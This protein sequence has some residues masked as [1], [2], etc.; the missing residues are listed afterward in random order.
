M[1]L[2]IILF[3]LLIASIV[4]CQLPVMQLLFRLDLS[5]PNHPSIY[6]SMPQPVIVCFI[7]TKRDGVFDHSV[8]VFHDS[9][10]VSF[11]GHLTAFISTR[12]TIHFENAE[13]LFFLFY[14]LY[15]FILPTFY[16]HGNQ[17]RGRRKEGT[18]L[19]H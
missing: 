18:N 13:T 6:L 10:S 3:V 19:L 11:H 15:E 7:H 9:V 14:D 1:I 8:C 12:V 17:C 16:R 4:S 5:P 2:F